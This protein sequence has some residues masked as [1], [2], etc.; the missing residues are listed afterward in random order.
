M[1]KPKDEKPT[2]LEKFKALARELD[3]PLDA[4]AF[5][6][7]IGGA[8]GTKPPTKEEAFQAKREGKAD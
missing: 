1:T 6:Q 4:D 3:A 8:R 7:I 2:Q 5:D